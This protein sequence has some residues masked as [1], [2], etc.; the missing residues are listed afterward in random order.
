MSGLLWRTL[1]TEIKMM[2]IKLFLGICKWADW[3]SVW[4]KSAIKMLNTFAWSLIIESII[5][6]FIV[7]LSHDT[8]IL[9]AF[10]LALSLIRVISCLKRQFCD[11]IDDRACGR[12]A[13][14][15]M[16][17][18]KTIL[19]IRINKS[20]LIIFWMILEGSLVLSGNL[21]LLIDWVT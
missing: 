21:E 4:F 19:D 20:T 18:T 13:N 16:S 5:S 8:N 17:Q 15:P 10:L 6:E 3:L 11:S 1:M 14:A 7:M 9:D 2:S 12:C